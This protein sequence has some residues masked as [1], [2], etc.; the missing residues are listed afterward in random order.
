MNNHSA[1]SRGKSNGGRR[2]SN[3]KK[4]DASPPVPEGKRER[5]LDAAIKVFAAEGFYNAKVSQIAHEAGV[6][7]GTI[8]LYFK[9]KDD[10]LINLFEDRMEMVNANLREAI[11]TEST[12]EARLR[13]IVK[14]HLE[15]VEQNRDMAEVISVE[16]RQSSKFIREYSNPKFAE[17]LRT[18]AGAVVEGQRTGELRTGIDPYVFAR[19]L[20]GAL[21]EIALA[22]LVKHPGSKASIELPRAAE[23]LG[24][25]FIDG[26]KA[27]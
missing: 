10:L 18:I 11:E 3:G 22:W 20:F 9:S 15:L 13:R 4:K 12:A 25:L 5:I 16:L 24:D 7:D 8:Y 19:A 17:F 2:A 23:Q 6:A 26:L 1:R 21:D 14:L 27:R